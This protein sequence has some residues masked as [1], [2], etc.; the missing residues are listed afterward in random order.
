MGG[1]TQLKI[2]GTKPAERLKKY[3]NSPLRP[4]ISLASW[5]SS[6]VTDIPVRS[7]A[8]LQDVKRTPSNALVSFAITQSQTIIHVGQ[9]HNKKIP[10]QVIIY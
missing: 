2:V 7:F 6:K 5:T 10:P 3:G 9:Q 1:Y 4:Y 8:L